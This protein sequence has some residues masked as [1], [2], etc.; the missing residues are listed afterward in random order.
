MNATTTQT[1]RGLPLPDGMST[2]QIDGARLAYRE[3]GS[4]E[5]V[6][7]VHGSI[8]DLTIWERQLA[9]VG[10]RHRAIAYSRRYAWPNDDLPTGAPDTMAPHVDDLLAFLR[11]VDAY[12]A[13][14]VGNSWGAFICLRTAMQEPAAVRSLVLEEPPLVPLIT[15]APPAPAQILSSLLR[16]PQVTLGVMRF[17]AQTLTAVGRLIEAGD[18]EGSIVRFARGVL[19]EQALAGLP[20]EVRAHMLANASTHIGQFQAD[21]GFE[22]ITETEIRS[23]TTPALV[24]TG[25]QSPVFLRRLAELLAGLLPHSRSLEVPGAS[26]AMHVEN[27]DAVNAALLRFFAEITEPTR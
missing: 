7:F 6:V 4:G 8:S 16:H 23:I 1:I 15:G 20:P 24:I 3:R 12:P 18:I 14:L 22:P 5:P 11:A 19:G 13:H 10:E 27:P 25:A 2:A 9:P 21:G 17:G 26:H